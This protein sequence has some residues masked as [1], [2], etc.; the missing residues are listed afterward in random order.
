VSI[1][2]DYM[3]PVPVPSSEVHGGLETDAIF[4]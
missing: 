2:A 4:D 3:V 1:Q